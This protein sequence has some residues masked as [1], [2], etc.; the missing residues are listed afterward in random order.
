[1]AASGSFGFVRGSPPPLFISVMAP[2]VT[3][4]PRPLTTPLCALGTPTPS[5]SHARS[6]ARTHLRECQ[7]SLPCDSRGRTRASTFSFYAVAESRCNKSQ[8]VAYVRWMPRC[9][10]G[11]EVNDDEAPAGCV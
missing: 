9:S 6:H 11:S 4:Q 10:G 2:K 3:C 7:R 8:Q 1:M 5:G